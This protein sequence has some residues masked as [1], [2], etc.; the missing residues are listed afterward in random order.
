MG[1]QGDRQEGPKVSEGFSGHGA[2][3]R[4][5]PDTDDAPKRKYGG[6]DEHKLSRGEAVSSETAMV[7]MRTTDQGPC[8]WELQERMQL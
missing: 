2:R 6:N 7:D 3:P 4:G 5:H 8:E 1:A